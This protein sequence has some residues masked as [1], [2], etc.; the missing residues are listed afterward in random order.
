MKITYKLIMKIFAGFILYAI[1][2]TMTI[3]ANLG[4]SCWDVFHQGIAKTFGITFGQASIAV[5]IG[6]IILNTIFKER[7]GWGTIGNIIMIGLLVDFLLQNNIIPVCHGF[8]SGIIMLLLGLFVIAI[9]TVT[10]LSCSIGSGP[11]DGLMVFLTKKTGKPVGLIR[12]IVEISVLIIGYFL[13]GY[14]GI[15]T[16]ISSV[17]IGPIIQITFKLFK[18]DVYEIKH[19]FIDEDIKYLYEKINNT[20]KKE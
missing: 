10:Y 18:F 12:T 3:N 20:S 8:F 7:I 11:R 6:I 19:R 2:I 14:V 13:G 4:L 16:L 15:G 1:G 9:A 5:G 17:S